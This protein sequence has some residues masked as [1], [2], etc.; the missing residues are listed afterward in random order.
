MVQQSFHDRIARIN[1]KSGQVE[2]LAG[3]AEGNG[4]GGTSGAALRG[5]DGP[6]RPGFLK[7]LMIGMLMV[8]VGMAIS[9]MTKLFLDPE[10]TPAAA[11]Y[12]TLMG[13]VV[14]AHVALAGGAITAIAS[15]FR[16]STLNYV[17]LF[18]F[19]GYGIA[20]AALAAALQ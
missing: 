10:I 6:R 9:L 5:A 17:L 4:S 2:M 7:I 20:S 16:R 19:A 15:R 12:M 3:V 18:V 8:P 14:L 13:F 1:Q 11:H